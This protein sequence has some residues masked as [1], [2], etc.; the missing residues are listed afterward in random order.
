M[1][2]AL[3]GKKIGMTQVFDE[4]NRLV[5]VTV[6]EAGP[7]PVTQV[8]TSEKDGYSAVQIGYRAQKEHRLSKAALGHFKKAGVEP[9]AELREFRVAAEGELNVGDVLTVEK[10]EAGQK[11]DVIGTTKGRGFQGVVKRWGFHGGPASHGSMFHRRGGSYGMCQWPGHVI[12]GKKMPGH[13]GDKQRTVQN[14]TVVK[15][16]ADKNLILVKGSIPGSRGGLVTVRTAIK[17]KTPKA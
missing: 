17:N 9:L 6:I 11:I 13:M 16:L 4:N 7:C 1:K 10:F 12:K 5:P 14:L 15:V 8:K 3:L 2:V